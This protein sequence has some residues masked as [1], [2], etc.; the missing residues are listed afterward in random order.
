MTQRP[1]APE[2]LARWTAVDRYYEAL[3]E[4][5][6]PVLEA[7]LRAS[8]AAGL[9]DIQVSPLQGKLLQLLAKAVR[10][11]RILEIG[12][13]GGY[14]AIWLGRALD[15]GGRLVTLELEP[16]HAAVARANLLRAGLS[17]RVE[18][19]VGPAQETLPALAKEKGAPFDLVFID[20]DK[21]AYPEYLEWAVRLSHE[22]TVIVADNVVRR[23]D[24]VDAHSRDPNVQGVRRMH[25][26][27]HGD[28][29]LSATVLQ[30]V[31]VKGYDGFTLAVV[32]ADPGGRPP[33]RLEGR[34]SSGEP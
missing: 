26:R 5:P 10:A 32:A 18:V 25:E 33:R 19:R 9:P 12:T 34:P 23:G 22:G 11:R 4:P 6:D 30:T 8:A 13:L 28:P 3:L 29:R 7:A 20:A 24:V 16:A 2:E 27:L 31:G 21:P 1:S 17:D 15:P 14:S